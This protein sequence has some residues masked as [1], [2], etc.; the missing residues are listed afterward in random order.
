MDLLGDLVPQRQADEGHGIRQ[1]D[2]S[3]RWCCERLGVLAGSALV[4]GDL[5]LDLAPRLALHLQDDVE[6]SGLDHARGGLD[7]VDRRAAERQRSPRLVQDVVELVEEV[8]D[9]AADKTVDVLGGAR[10]GGREAVLEQGAALEQEVWLPVEVQCALKDGDDDGRGDEPAQA[11]A[12][13]PDLLLGLIDP[14]AEHARR[15]R[16]L[17]LGLELGERAGQVRELCHGL[18]VSF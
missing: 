5:D 16:R 15:G 12:V 9:I 4:R 17:G 7:D 18:R 8:G 3:E 14:A 11:S 1:T 13:G 2:G 10:G 6:A